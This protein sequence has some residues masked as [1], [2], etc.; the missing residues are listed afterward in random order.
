MPELDRPAQPIRNP[1]DK[2]NTCKTTSGTRQPRFLAGMFYLQEMVQSPA[3]KLPIDFFFRSLSKE[4]GPAI[5]CCHPGADKSVKH[6]SR[7]VRLKWKD[8]QAAG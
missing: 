4:K 5:V 7:L 6:G 2:A 1:P 8:T 3:L